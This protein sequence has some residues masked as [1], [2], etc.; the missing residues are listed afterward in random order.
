MT[1]N[2]CMPGSSGDV[3]D[4]KKK[5]DD[6]GKDDDEKKDDDV[7]AYTP[8]GHVPGHIYNCRTHRFEPR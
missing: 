7:E 6:T 8:P 2:D 1:V 5:D 3:Y 4:D